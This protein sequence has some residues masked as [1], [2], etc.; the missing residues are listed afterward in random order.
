MLSI[1]AARSGRD[2]MRLDAGGRGARVPG[3]VADRWSRAA[4]KLYGRGGGRRGVEFWRRRT[5]TTRRSSDGSWRVDAAVTVRTSYRSRYRSATR[6][7]AIKRCERGGAYGPSSVSVAARPHPSVTSGVFDV[8]RRHAFSTDRGVPARTWPRARSVASRIPA[9]PQSARVRLRRDRDCAAVA[10]ERDAAVRPA[11]PSSST[12]ALD[13]PPR[14]A[15]DEARTRAAVDRWRAATTAPGRTCRRVCAGCRRPRQRALRPGQHGRP[16]L[17]TRTGFALDYQLNESGGC[18]ATWTRRSARPTF[19]ERVPVR[20]LG[21]TETIGWFFQFQGTV[22]RPGG[23]ALEG[24][25]DPLDCAALDP[26]TR[27]RRSTPPRPRAVP[28]REE[29]LRGDAELSLLVL[30]DCFEPRCRRAA[31]G[32]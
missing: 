4:P 29:R 17:A 1:A 25:V 26:T 24:V 8:A 22:A 32:P 21:D 16:L 19:R 14:R 30:A 27:P 15:E 7:W 28:L 10:R 31:R 6:P 18:G 5:R 11:R 9:R 12:P 23:A 2:G 13:D 3:G 20:R